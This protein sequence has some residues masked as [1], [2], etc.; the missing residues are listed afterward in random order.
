MFNGK[1]VNTNIVLDLMREKVNCFRQINDFINRIKNDGA[2][3]PSTHGLFRVK[4][5]YTRHA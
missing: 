1:N 4:R 3:I 2:S 5:L